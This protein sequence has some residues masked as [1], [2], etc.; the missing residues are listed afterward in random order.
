MCVGH[1]TSA[2]ALTWALY[3]LAQHPA[4]QARLRAELQ[5][6]PLLSSLSSPPTATS[7]TAPAPAAS[8]P[9]PTADALAPLLRLPYLDAVV[10]EALRLHAP[11]TTTMRVAT[12]PCALPLSAPVRDRAGAWRTHIELRAGDIVSVPI[13]AANVRAEAWGADAAVFRPERWL[14]RGDDDDFGEE[15]AEGEGEGEGG[16]REKAGERRA[17]GLWGGLLTFGLAGGARA[18]DR[19]C[20]G[21]RFAVNEC[22]S[23][24]RSSSL[25]P[26]AALTGV[27]VARMK[28]FLAV[29]VRDIAFAL[30][31]GVEIEKRVKYVSSASPLLAGVVWQRC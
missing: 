30:D 12:R 5:S 11:I 2:S 18:G 3:A 6:L 28:L 9:P 1:E 7:F 29:L 26:V 22:V 8:A 31:A 20:I 19:S 25:C 23:L 10:R 15:E 27:C 24:R 13:G 14:A 21:F 16:G 4:A 17:R